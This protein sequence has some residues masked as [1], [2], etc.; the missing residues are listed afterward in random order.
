MKMRLSV[1]LW[2]LALVACSKPEDAAKAPQAENTR[3]VLVHVVG[4]NAD[5]GL[6]TY[7]GEV[8]PRIDSALAFRVP[9]K[10]VSRK[11]DVG[12]RVKPGDE[13][14]RLDPSD[15]NLNLA[16]STA[17]LA[18]AAAERDFAQSELAR[19]ADLRDRHFI[20]QAVYDQ[21]ANAKATA[22]ARYDAVKAQMAVSRNQTDYTVLRADATGVV[23]QVLA[24]PGQVVNAGQAV[25]HIARDGEKEVAI[26]VPES[27]MKELSK[28]RGQTQS[29]QI[30]LWADGVGAKVYQGRIREIAPVAD[31]Q[32]RTYPVRVSIVNADGGVLLGMTATVSFR[33]GDDAPHVTIPLAA[34]F[35]KDSKPAVWVLTADNHASLR[36]V[37]VAAY[38]EKGAEISAGVQVGE[39]LVAAGVHKLVSGEKLNVLAPSGAGGSAPTA[40]AAAPK[41]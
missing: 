34:V 1:I 39:R 32:T 38:T 29:A 28:L 36:P 6:T 26:S 35:Q 18:A 30:T 33:S 21:K 24:E 17:Q 16:N 25:M 41:S 31:S 7:S 11:V 40:P 15:N 2:A 37:T 10:I 9:G 4:Q 5:A 14:A 20:S 12:A 23:D 19:Y 22:Q 3:P 8:R 13:L 27:R